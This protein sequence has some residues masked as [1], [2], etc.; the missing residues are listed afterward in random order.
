MITATISMPSVTIPAGLAPDG[1]TVVPAVV[2]PAKA[3]LTLSATPSEYTVSTQD[4]LASVRTMQGKVFTDWTAS[5]KTYSFNFGLI[6]Y[7]EFCTLE[8]Y[9]LAQKNE[10]REVLLTITNSC[11]TCEEPTNLS[12]IMS[13]SDRSVIAGGSY[14]E[15][16]TLTFEEIGTCL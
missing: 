12:V 7:D 1:I 2:I 13:I 4:V 11:Q 15:N 8:E 16:F 5:Y 9:Y 6:D 14:I 10:Q 3:V